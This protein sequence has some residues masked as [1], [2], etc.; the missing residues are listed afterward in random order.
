MNKQKTKSMLSESKG[1]ILRRTAAV[2]LSLTILP[3]TELPAMTDAASPVTLTSK[4]INASKAIGINNDAAPDGFDEDDD[5]NNPY[6]K[7][8]VVF[9]DADEVYSM[10]TGMSDGSIIGD[11]VSNVGSQCKKEITCQNTQWVDRDGNEVTRFISEIGV[12][13]EPYYW[14]NGKWN[15]NLAKAVNDL[16]QAGYEEIVTYSNTLYDESNLAGTDVGVGKYGDANMHYPYNGEGVARYNIAI[17]YNYTTDIRDAI[18]DVML[19][20]DNDYDQAPVQEYYYQGRLYEAAPV[21]GCSDFQNCYG[22]LNM[23]YNWDTNNAWTL[24]LVYSRMNKAASPEIT[25]CTGLSMHPYGGKGNNSHLGVGSF[26]WN[27]SEY[28][29]FEEHTDLNAEM[30]NRWLP[31]VYL[32]QTAQTVRPLRIEGSTVSGKAKIQEK[33]AINKTAGGNFDGNT[34]G[35]KNHFAMVAAVDGELQL[36]VVDAKDPENSQTVKTLGTYSNKSEVT[37][38]AQMSIVSGDFDGND[39]DDIAVYNPY[40]TD[41]SRVEIYSKTGSGS[42]DD[43]NSWEIK[44]TISVATDDVISLSVGDINNDGIDDLVVAANDGVNVYSGARKN[45]LSENEQVCDNSEADHFSATV[46]RDKITG[47]YQN[48]IAVLGAGKE[49]LTSGKLSVFSRDNKGNYTAVATTDVKFTDVSPLTKANHKYQLD[50]VYADDRLISPY[51]N[52]QTY[53][54]A[55]GKLTEEKLTKLANSNENFCFSSNNYGQE[56]SVPE[57]HLPY[58][59]QVADLNGNGEQTVFFKTMTLKW[60]ATGFL[61]YYSFAAI[62]PTEKDS[63]YMS[64][65]INASQN[66]HY[67]YAVVNTDNDSSYLTYTGKHWFSY[68]DPAVLAV[69]ASPPYFKDLLEKDD[70]SGFYEGSITSYGKTKGSGSSNSKAA[71][72][73][74]GAYIKY[75]HDFSVFGVKVASIEAEIETMAHFTTEFEQA[76]E[77]SYTTEYTTSSGADA[78]VFYSIPYE[79]YEYDM[80][81]YCNGEKYTNKQTIAIPKQPCTST[82]EMEKYK[83]ISSMYHEL[84]QLSDDVLRHTLGKPETY[85]QNTTGYHNVQEFDGNYMAVDFTSVGG[86]MSQSQ[87]IEM[88]EEKGNSYSTGVDVTVSAGAGPGDVTIGVKAGVGAEAS[89]ATTS[90]NGCSFTAE[91]QNM[92][93]EAEE[94]GYGMSWK[95]FAH[96]GTYTDYKGNTVTFPVVDYL[97]TDVIQPPLIPRDFHQNYQESTQNSIRLE[98]KYEDPSIAE[99]F[100]I[101]RITDIN[102]RDSA[103]L[104]GSVAASGGTKGDDGIYSYVFTDSGQSENSKNITMNSGTKFDYSI[105]AVRSFTAPPP[106][107]MPGATISAYTLSDAEYPDIVLKGIENNKLTLYP[108]RDYTITADVQNADNFLQLSYQWQKRDNKN[109][110][111]NIKGGNTKVFEITNST[112][113]DA[114]QYRCWIDALYYNE[115]RHEKSALS[116]A[117]DEID[118]TYQMR[119]VKKDSFMVSC[120][121]SKPEAILTLIPEDPY[122]F[123]TPTGDIRFIIRSTSLEK[124]YTVP[125]KTSGKKATAKLSTAADLSELPEGVYEITAYYSGDNVFSSFTESN[126]QSVLVGESKIYP[127]LMNENGERTDTFYYGDKMFV[128]FLNYTKDDDGNTTETEMKD[129]THPDGYSELLTK[130]PDIYVNNEIKVKLQGIDDEQTFHYTY[131]VT[132]RPITVRVIS[133][134]LFAGDVE[135]HLPQMDILS[136]S[137][138]ADDVLSDIVDLSFKNSTGTTNISITNSTNPGTYF[139][140]LSA[141]SSETAENYDIKL[142]SSAF[143]INSQQ[144]ALTFSAEPCEGEQAGTI[145]LTLPETKSGIT[146]ETFCYESGTKLKFTAEAN[147]GYKFDHWVINNEEY[148]TETV[149]KN[150]LREA[151]SVQVFFKPYNGR[152]SIDETELSRVETPEGFENGKEYPVG[153]ELTFTAQNNENSLFDHWVK[154][155]GS[156]T[157]E[158]YTNSITLTVT[159]IPV[160]LYPVFSDTSH[161][162]PHVEDILAKYGYDLGDVNNDGQINSVDASSILAYYAKI[163]TNQDGGYSDV[164]KAAADVNND[165]SVNSVDASKI[166]AYYAYVSTTQEEVMTLEKFMNK[167][168]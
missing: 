53:I 10:K 89:W 165:G 153:T 103:V 72:I 102:G 75:E 82:V 147:N 42:V 143:T 70:L 146:N 131:T 11:D 132:K 55:E 109:N 100:N 129:E 168:T 4:T 125:L 8:T 130:K 107:S 99:K 12:A 20:T 157:T 93:K 73:S 34:E 49:S 48:F 7:K 26:K 83:Q 38:A 137:L 58:D 31:D 117:T 139:A 150:M 78:V 69:L 47:Q 52:M 41:G 45:M 28:A 5:K 97:V 134:E 160:M 126:K 23:G 64:S 76:C 27:G 15:S 88:T 13:A 18:N 154:V 1:S 17:G 111:K 43:I 151:M 114:G 142:Y 91:M 16:K 60:K 61:R 86:G 36:A 148:T 119:T 162:I 2:L 133:E 152:I 113:E 121:E 37:L 98:W 56:T 145:K 71:T 25:V 124:S 22:N 144:Y 108:D 44:R 140:Q 101:Y 96:D 39:I 57:Y 155:T 90:T 158:L 35:K 85:P 54:F 46:F 141:L 14:S 104:V 136:G 163:S 122:C 94:Y 24:F 149:T 6:G 63:I 105:E 84:P 62:T 164:Q 74:A 79:F 92:P 30:D 95:L 167:A 59:I 156:K 81:Y 68:T 66:T 21:Y 65:T 29:F 115:E 138:A 128:K 159:D 3:L 166:L 116:I 80:V 40:H 120:K 110:W 106:V 161:E 112:S 87:S 51:F 19:L 9:G 33:S 118:V 127:V 123:V 50:L 77:I 32:H 135:G 67:C